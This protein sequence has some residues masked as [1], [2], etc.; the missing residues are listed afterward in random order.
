MGLSWPKIRRAEQIGST[1]FVR[2]TWPVA[3]AARLG[4][5]MFLRSQDSA[6]WRRVTSTHVEIPRT[7]LNDAQ[8][9][10]HLRKDLLCLSFLCSDVFCASSTSSL[11]SLCTHAMQDTRAGNVGERSQKE[12]NPESPSCQL[13]LCINIDARQRHTKQGPVAAGGIHTLQRGTSRCERGRLA[14]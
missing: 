2:Q 12:P 1:T 14:N 6:S 4:C 8:H 7:G 11:C 13:V 9:M 10:C 5:N 3:F